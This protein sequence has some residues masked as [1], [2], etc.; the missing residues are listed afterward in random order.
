[1]SE[2]MWLS[3]VIPTG[4]ILDGMLGISCFAKGFNM[5]LVNKTGDTAIVKM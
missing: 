1:M 4:F 2:F 3:P 5:N